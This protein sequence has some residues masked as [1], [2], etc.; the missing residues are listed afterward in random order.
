MLCERLTAPL[1]RAGYIRAQNVAYVRPDFRA[2]PNPPHSHAVR[3]DGLH[4]FFPTQCLLG[5]VTSHAAYEDCLFPPRME[6]MNR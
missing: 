4:R 6:R 5:G 1:T 2:A 3:C